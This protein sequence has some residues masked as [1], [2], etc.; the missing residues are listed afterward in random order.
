VHLRA[1]D[2]RRTASMVEKE[3]KARQ[4]LE[5]LKCI[6]SELS[7]CWWKKDFKYYIDKFIEERLV[8]K[9]FVT[10]IP[11][12]DE[13]E[14][15]QDCI[16]LHALRHLVAGAIQEWELVQQPKHAAMYARLDGALVWQGRGYVNPVLHV[17]SSLQIIFTE[18][19]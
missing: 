15:E 1:V 5:D 3:E 9:E 17:I 16:Y 12:E 18:L 19:I 7:P 14:E 2:P 10:S 4:H 13:N 8:E 11:C 6:L